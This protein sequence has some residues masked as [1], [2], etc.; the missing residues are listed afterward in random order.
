V[1]LQGATR[2]L[3]GGMATTSDV[4]DAQARLHASRRDLAQARYDHLMSRLRLMAAS[5]MPHDE[6]VADVNR[7][8]GVPA[9]ASAP[10]PA[11]TAAPAAA[12]AETANAA[13]AALSTPNAT[14]A[15]AVRQP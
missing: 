4:L 8:L 7:L 12:S 2:S 1:T 15:P 5:G 10:P 9:T 14:A 6:V 11:A 13:T 3:D